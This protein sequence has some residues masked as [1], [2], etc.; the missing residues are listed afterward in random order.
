MKIIFN[1]ISNVAGGGV[2]NSANFIY[3]ALKDKRHEYLFLVS[4]PVNS[5]LESWGVN[6]KSI[7][8]FDDR[9]RVLD[10]QRKVRWLEREFKPQ[11][12]YTMAGPNLL[13]FKSFHMLGTSNPYITHA[14]KINYFWD[15]SILKGIK[16]ICSAMFK[17]WIARL[18]G[19]FYVFQTPTSRKGFCKRFL[20]P[21]NKTAVI[22]NAI[23][24][25]FVDNITSYTPWSG[26]D[27]PKV[28]LCASAYYS[29]KNIEIL[30]RT[31]RLLKERGE[32]NVKFLLTI[33]NQSFSELTQRYD[34]SDNMILN[35]GPYNYSKAID[36]YKKADAIVLPSLLETFSTVYIEAIALGLPIFIP[37][38][39]FAK[40]I[41]Q[42][43]AIYYDS[44]SEISLMNAIV[45]S[46]ND[47][48]ESYKNRIKSII[49]S[50]YG[51]Q[52]ERYEKIAL[53]FNRVA[54]L[55]NL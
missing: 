24:A 43:Y 9:K 35:I 21:I 6:H 53:L 12:V 47:E 52:E 40:D 30:F 33:D 48:V 42:D 32:L 4:R 44:L 49:L 36:I 20:C 1:C 28:I 50:G 39:S 5:V 19:D 13:C 51:N 7:I 3:Y 37:K 26:V 54:E 46:E 55:H 17:G 25:D 16:S 29:H 15:R 23:G 8:V 38:E 41:C 27:R 11:L 31:A 2:Q 45:S 10:T 34:N 18:S 14:K 22:P